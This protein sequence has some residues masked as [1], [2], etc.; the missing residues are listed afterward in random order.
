LDHKEQRW[1]EISEKGSHKLQEVHNIASQS[2]R[3]ELNTFDI[4]GMED[5]W[6]LIN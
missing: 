6:M 2:I 3:E 1:N 4:P 5:E